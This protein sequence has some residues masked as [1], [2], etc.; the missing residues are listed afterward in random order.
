LLAIFILLAILFG[1]VGTPP[2]SVP[3]DTA[4]LLD[5]G[6]R[7]INGQVPHADFHTPIG[8][9]TYLLAAFGMKIAPPSAS[10][11]TYG[12]VLLMAILLPW[13]WHIAAKRLPWAVAFIFVLFLG[14]FLITPRA[15]GYE[16]RH[17]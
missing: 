11:M 12:I 6:W 9:L 13:A 5:G 1:L 2:I 7:I 16:I 17:T 14:V 15:P 8:P 10:S 4:I 3:W